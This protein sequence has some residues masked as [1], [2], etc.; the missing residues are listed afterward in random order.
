MKTLLLAFLALTSLSAVAASFKHPTCKASVVS[1]E[2]EYSG[3]NDQAL[4]RQLE[5]NGFDFSEVSGEENEG[6]I[7]L[8]AQIV[9]MDNPT[10]L[11]PD[12]FVSVEVLD[13]GTKAELAPIASKSFISNLLQPTERLLKSAQKY[14]FAN[15]PVC[16]KTI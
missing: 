7:F 3:V 14:F 16:K 15:L 2:A 1:L 6:M 8:N 5:K 12:F 11:K 9:I 4:V 13:A 10:K